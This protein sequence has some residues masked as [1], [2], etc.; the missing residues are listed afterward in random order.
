[1]ITSA[2][3]NALSCCHVSGWIVA[4]MSSW[5]HVPNEAASDGVINVIEVTPLCGKI[6]LIAGKWIGGMWRARG[7]INSTVKVLAGLG[8]KSLWREHQHYFHSRLA[9]APQMM[10]QTHKGRGSAKLMMLQQEHKWT[11]SCIH[12]HKAKERETVHNHTDLH[13]QG[14]HPQIAISFTLTDAEWKTLSPASL[15]GVL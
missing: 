5:T 7:W 1:M 12:T 3:L 4:L 13:T 6:L 14:V 2:S 8:T 15:R 10:T 9:W 11:R